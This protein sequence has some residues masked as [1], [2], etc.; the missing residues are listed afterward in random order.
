V[1][2]AADLFRQYTETYESRNQIEMSLA[3]Y[4]ETCR[5]DP[6][7]YASAAERMVAAIGEP[8]I[9]DTSK[10]PRLGRVFMNRTIKVYPAVSDFFGLEETI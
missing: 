6:M 8:Q 3:E 2:T 4:L 7:A 5:D 10:D 9:L 1:L